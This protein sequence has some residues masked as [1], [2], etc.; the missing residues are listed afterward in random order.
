MGNSA[1]NKAHAQDGTNG[2]AVLGV[3]GVTVLD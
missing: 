2:L 3:C 1:K